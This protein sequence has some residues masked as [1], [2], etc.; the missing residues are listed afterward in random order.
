MTAN[1]TQK[2]G[3][4]LSYFSHIYVTFSKAES[5][6]ILFPLKNAAEGR[7]CELTATL[8]PGRQGQCEIQVPR[9]V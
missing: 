7:L 2:S 3:N 4:G 8:A 6:A 1:D 5:A 9:Y